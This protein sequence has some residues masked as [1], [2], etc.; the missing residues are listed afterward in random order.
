MYNIENATLNER[1]QVGDS[2]RER[3]VLVVGD[4]LAGCLLAGFLDER[5]FE[6]TLSPADGE[7]FVPATGRTT[8]PDAIDSNQLGV[9][10]V[11]D[12]ETAY[13]DLAVGT[14]GDRVF[15]DGQDR[16]RVAV[17]PRL[18]PGSV[19]STATGLAT[20][21]ALADALSEA[22]SVPFALKRYRRCRGALG[23]DC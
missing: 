18:R 12:G 20:L 23:N 6:V 8:E 19:V 10:A 16:R 2:H 22:E 21:V 17:V 14:G 15:L 13:Y 11:Y 3:R 7:P 1:R 9:R 4:A 5:G